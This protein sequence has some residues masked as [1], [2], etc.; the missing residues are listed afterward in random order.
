MLLFLSYSEH[1][2]LR[3]A[4]RNL[5]ASDVEYTLTNGRECRRGAAIHYTLRGK[6]IPKP[7]RRNNEIKR[8]E[9]VTVLIA[10][11]DNQIITVYRNKEASK[12][13]RKKMKY[14]RKKSYYNNLPLAV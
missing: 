3:M 14:N 8:L 7:D 5:S 2:L 12:N 11:D 4:Q 1:A 9:G 6:D 13:T 10:P